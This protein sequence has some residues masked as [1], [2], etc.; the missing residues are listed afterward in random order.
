MLFQGWEDVAGVAALAVI[1]YAGLVAI[2]R[3]SGKRTLAQL[4]AF[5]WL[6]TVALGTTL[7]TTILSR[8]VAL[9]EGVTALVTLVA[10]QFVVALVSSRSDR[11]RRAFTSEPALLVHRGRLLH[12]TMRRERVSETEVL[13]ALREQ[14]VGSVDEVDAVVLETNGRFAVVPTGSAG[15]E[16]ALAPIDRR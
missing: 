5:D 7:S 15:R 2:L 8:E 1:A 12:E 11:A 6:V 13:Q 9:A 4:N 14:G 10:L 3:V 16:D